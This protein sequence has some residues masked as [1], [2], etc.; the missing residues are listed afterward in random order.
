MTKPIRDVIMDT[1]SRYGNLIPDNLKASVAHEITS[2]LVSG[3]YIDTDDQPSFVADNSDISEKKYKETKLQDEI[4]MLEKSVR[5]KEPGLTNVDKAYLEREVIAKEERALQ[6][7]A[8]AGTF[9]EKATKKKRPTSSTTTKSKRKAS[10]PPTSSKEQITVTPSE[11]GVPTTEDDR[12]STTQ[13]EVK[14]I[15][16]ESKMKQVRSEDPKKEIPETKEATPRKNK[17]LESIGE[18]YSDKTKPK[19]QGN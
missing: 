6:Q 13:R 12:L 7:N 5:L 2:E 19:S 15:E 9:E 17:G 11:E 8:M 1:M 18:K 3:G 14:Q 10:T 4:N 16:S